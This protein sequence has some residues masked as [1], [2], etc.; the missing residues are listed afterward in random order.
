[1]LENSDSFYLVLAGGVTPA[2]PAPLESVRSQIS[3]E[4]K[5]E[6]NRELAAAQLSPAVGKVQ[7]GQSMVEVAAELGLTHAITDTFT[8]TS[9]VADVGYGTAFNE[10]ALSAPVGQLLPE[11][12]TLRGIYAVRPIWQQ[13]IAEDDFEAR[14]DG[15]HAS[16][17]ARKQN[18][19]LNGWFETKLAAADIVDLRD[20]ARQGT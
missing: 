4:L 15:I 6:H 9:N 1:V 16:L 2:G 8:V 17:L 12:A 13:P 7:L 20:E 11:V 14:R 19:L 5:R 3:V 18:A 10:V